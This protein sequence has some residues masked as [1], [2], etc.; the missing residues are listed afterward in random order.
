MSEPDPREQRRYRRLTVRIDVSYL[1]L[2]EGRVASALA[3]TLGAGG[4]FIR[5]DDPLAPGEALRV[6]F[7]LP[8]AA[9]EHELEARVVWANHAHTP[10][11][12][13]SGRGMGVAF[14]DPRAQARLASDLVGW[15]PPGS[16]D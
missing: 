7:R 15:S 13:D 10:G 11:V 9:R 8:G 6:R 14:R 4:L 5:T 12:P 16:A 2:R 1:A 3:T